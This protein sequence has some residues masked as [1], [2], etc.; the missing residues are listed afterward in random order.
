VIYAEDAA[1][2]ALDYASWAVWQAEPTVLDAI[3]ARARADERTTA[4]KAR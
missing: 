1:V 4:S 2:E 3:E